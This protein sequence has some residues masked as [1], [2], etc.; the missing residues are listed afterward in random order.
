MSPRADRGL[1]SPGRGGLLRGA[2]TCRSQSQRRDKNSGKRFSELERQA[3]IGAIVQTNSRLLPESFSPDRSPHP[4]YVN[5][6][7][8]RKGE[9]AK[10]RL[11][12]PGATRTRRRGDWGDAG[13]GEGSKE[14]SHDKAKAPF[15]FW[16]SAR[17]P[18]HRHRITP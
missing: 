10:G 17:P 15:A 8:A 18:S 2:D 12:G 5:I 3:P 6:S 14:R 1:W 7:R 11:G 9:G 4:D 13:R 16:A